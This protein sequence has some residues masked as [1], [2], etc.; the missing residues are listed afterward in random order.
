[1]NSEGAAKISGAN[2]ND[3]RYLVTLNTL[4]LIVV[5]IV[6]ASL[7]IG[8]YGIPV[9]DAIKILLSKIFPIHG[10]WDQTMENVIFSWVMPLNKSIWTSLRLGR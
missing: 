5:L 6:L 1:M 3:K 2:V 7:C 8:R 9:I 4:I 10:T